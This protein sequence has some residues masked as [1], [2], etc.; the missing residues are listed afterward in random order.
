MIE[1]LWRRYGDDDEEYAEVAVSGPITYHGKSGE[2][3]GLLDGQS[4]T[5]IDYAKKR[6]ADTIVMHPSA[7]LQGVQYT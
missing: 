4:W 7:W 2:F 1:D 6:E 3:V 5:C